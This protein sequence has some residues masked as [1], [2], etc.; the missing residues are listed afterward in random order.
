MPKGDKEYK[1]YK[2]DTQTSHAYQIKS[3]KWK[4]RELYLN[5]K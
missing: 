4:T 1:T 5:R 3:I 2:K